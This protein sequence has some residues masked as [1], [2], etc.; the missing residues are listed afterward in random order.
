V[1]LCC[2]ADERSENGKRRWAAKAVAPAVDNLNSWR[3]ENRLQS[4]LFAMGGHGMTLGFE[5]Q[6]CDPAIDLTIKQ[7]DAKMPLN[8]D[9]D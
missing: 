5:K 1:S 6:H 9:F 4:R 8:Q 7:H 2:S 3:R